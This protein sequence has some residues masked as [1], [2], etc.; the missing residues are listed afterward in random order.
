[1]AALD[2]VTGAALLLQPRVVI[3]RFGA[4][5]D[6]TAIVPAARL[7]GLRYVIQ[8][9]VLA[10]APAKTAGWASATDG[11]HASS[12]IA[13]AILAPSYRRAAL[14]SAAMALI[15]G[16]ATIPRRALSGRRT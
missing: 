3:R 9:A 10:G 14:G 16:V 7:L 8:A 2:V 11:V 4:D 6:L 1:M 12:M 13:L 15:L 5:P